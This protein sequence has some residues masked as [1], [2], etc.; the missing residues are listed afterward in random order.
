MQQNLWRT[1]HQRKTDSDKKTEDT[2]SKKGGIGKRFWKVLVGDDDKPAAS[3]EV[4]F[5]RERVGFPARPTA[6][7][8]G[9]RPSGR[10]ASTLA[11]QISSRTSRRLTRQIPMAVCCLDEE[12]DWA[13]ELSAD[14]IPVT[15]LHRTAGFRPALS[16]AI[17]TVAQRHGANVIHCHHYSPFVYSCFARFWQPGCRVIFTEHGRLSDAAPS[18]KRRFANQVLRRF[19]SGVFTVSEDLRQHII[20]E[21]FAAGA[22]SVIYNGISV[23]PPP[24]SAARE[25]I[26]GWWMCPL[27]IVIERSRDSI[28]S[29]IS[30]L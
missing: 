26:R 20:A 15:A 7:A 22:V 16:R 29:R 3:R 24:D 6:A 9:P 19:P 1:R 5:T 23:G 18:A 2:G 13:S 4:S 28:T 21:G 30:E 12:G 11:G 8:V 14:R 17:A 25:Q 10:L 27:M